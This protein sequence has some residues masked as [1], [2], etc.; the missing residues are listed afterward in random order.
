MGLIKYRLTSNQRSQF[1]LSLHILCVC[2][3]H[4]IKNL[5]QGDGIMDSVGGDA[6]VAVAQVSNSGRLWDQDCE[7]KNVRGRF[8]MVEGVVL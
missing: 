6:C 7:G 1:N 8:S 4:D 5:F 2:D 3:C